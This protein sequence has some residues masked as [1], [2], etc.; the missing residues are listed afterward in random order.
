M[1][2][3]KGKRTPRKHRASGFTDVSEHIQAERESDP[4]LARM[5]DEELARMELARSLRSRRES[6]HLT[7]AELAEKIGTAQPA[8]ARFEAG[9]VNPSLEM[10][11]RIAS[12]LGM[13]LKVELTVPGKDER[14][15]G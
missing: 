5:M 7:Q 1:S 4:E 10:L 2:T 8:I 13:R 6:L 15:N 12:A 11:R 14:I 3:S 9:N